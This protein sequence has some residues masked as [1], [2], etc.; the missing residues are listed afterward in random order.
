MR[1]LISGLLL[2]GPLIYNTT[3]GSHGPGTF[4]HSSIH[5]WMKICM[6]DQRLL[7]VGVVV[8]MILIHYRYF[9]SKEVKVS[10][11]CERIT[12][13]GKKLR[14]VERVYCGCFGHNGPFLDLEKLSNFFVWMSNYV[15]SITTLRSHE[16]KRKSHLIYAGHIA[17]LL[18]PPPPHPQLDNVVR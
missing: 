14:C 2:C 12:M 9:N 18:S 16:S 6:N 8:E 13:R 10:L 7:T 5:G 17:F 1:L 11:L 4:I 15:M 3:L